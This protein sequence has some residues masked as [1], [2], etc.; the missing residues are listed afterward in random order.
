MPAPEPSSRP[1]PP[2]VAYLVSQYPKLSHAFIEREIRALRERGAV[3][4]TFSVRPTPER[5]LLSQRDRDEAATTTVLLPSPGRLLLAQLPLLARDPRAVARSLLRAVRTGAPTLRSRLWQAFY[6]LEAGVLVQQMQASGL[7]HV[8]VH[9]ANNGA[10]VARLAVPLGHELYGG[11]WSWSLAMHGPTEF[12]DVTGYDLAAKARAASF[13]A[14]ITDYCRSQLMAVVDPSHWAKLGLVRMSVD[15]DRFAVA[16]RDTSP[17]RPLRV[18][19]VGRL[20]PEKGPHVLVEAVS[21]LPA[22]SVEVRVVGDGPLREA[23]QQDVD[24]RGL[25]AAVTLVGPL[26]QEDLPAQYAWADV[27]TL[28]SFAEGLPVVIMEALASGCVVVT[29]RIAG[30]PELVE[31]GV[32]GVL[33]APGRAE[34]LAE[35]LVDVGADPDR[36]R[37]LALAGAQRVREHHAPGPN[38]AALAAMLP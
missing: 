24:A 9:L 38:A 30:I 21:M 19:Y 33:V 18:L 20:V 2:R 23:L 6:A 13:V 4:R 3:V 31:D 8:H 7:R 5:E 22:G 11:E 12:S 37:R 29:T 28:P 15:A 36:R 26:G 14:C 1:H 25:G 27:F 10:D 32:T 35:A 17:D 16:H 34:A